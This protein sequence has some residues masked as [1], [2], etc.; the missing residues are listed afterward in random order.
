MPNSAKQCHVLQ[1]VGFL[2]S[3]CIKQYFKSLYSCMTD[4][5]CLCQD[6]WGQIVTTNAVFGSN[7]ALF[8]P[9]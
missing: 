8:C 1:K 2:P 4:T 3:S 6:L 7:T 9:Q 5:L